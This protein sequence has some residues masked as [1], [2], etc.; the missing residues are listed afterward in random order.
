MADIFVVDCRG[1]NG[2][3]TRKRRLQ[4]ADR[5]EDSKNGVNGDDIR[6]HSVPSN[7]HLSGNVLPVPNVH[8]NFHGH[9]TATVPASGPAGILQHLLAIERPIR[10]ADFVDVR[11]VTDGGDA[12]RI[13]LVTSITKL[14]NLQL[15]DVVTWSRNLPG[16]SAL[17]LN[18]RTH[19]LVS[20]W[21]EILLLT[22]AFYSIQCTNA[23]AIAPNL[24]LTK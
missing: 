9:P 8:H 16:F 3:K 23:I 12:E 4:E 6:M 21:S 1:E 5:R 11:T 7:S 20:S 19:L 17:N 2:S 24:H 18:I 14:V 10:F 13:Q 22:N 15:T